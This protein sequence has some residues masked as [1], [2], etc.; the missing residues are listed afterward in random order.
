MKKHILLVASLIL[1][2]SLAAYSAGRSADATVD[3]KAAFDRLSKL[4]GEWEADT[5]MGKAHITYE[6]I[7]GGT[8]LS[9]RE[10]MEHM[11]PMQT[12]YYLDGKR[13]LLTHYCMTGNQPR[14]QAT[15]YRPDTGELQFAF[16]DATNLRSASDG[17]MHN[18]NFRLIDANHLQSEW[19]FYENGQ[20]K[21][22]ESF[23]FVRI[24]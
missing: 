9:E 5:S 20:K 8:A 14:M 1:V 19:E 21:A 4:V 22:T 7:A 13:L 10:T 16:F 18:A 6:V 11:P 2:L 15:A 24:R 12:I 23:S 17:H 3:G